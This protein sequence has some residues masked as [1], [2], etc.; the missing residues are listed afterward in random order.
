[1]FYKKTE[2][3]NIVLEF[4]GIVALNYAPKIHI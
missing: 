1:M 3:K 2:N 4:W